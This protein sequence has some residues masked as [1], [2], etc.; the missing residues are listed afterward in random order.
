MSFVTKV[1]QR[2]WPTVL[3][4]AIAVGLTLL[5]AHQQQPD[6]NYAELVSCAI[7]WGIVY[8]LLRISQ[9]SATSRDGVE[10]QG[11][12]K[13]WVVAGL[14]AGTE[15]LCGDMGWLWVSISCLHWVL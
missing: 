15:W 5:Q 12:W 14:V 9:A 8:G 3:P 7:A 10:G 1:F 13:Y 4:V 2:P 11:A 6:S